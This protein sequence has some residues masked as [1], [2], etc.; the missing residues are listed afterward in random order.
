MND[1]RAAAQASVVVTLVSALRARAWCLWALLA[2]YLVP[3]ISFVG[4][5]FWWDKVRAGS[6][7]GGIRVSSCGVDGSTA[8]SICKFYFGTSIF[9]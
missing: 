5:W 7:L 9:L 6:G 3:R 8:V 2:A 4:F 1:F